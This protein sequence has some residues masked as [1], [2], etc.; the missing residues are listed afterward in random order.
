VIPQSETE[1]N[2]LEG[3]TAKVRDKV[4]AVAQQAID[5]GTAV[6]EHVAEQA[7][8]SARAHGLSRDTSLGE[9]VEQAGSGELADAAENVGRDALNAAEQS[10]SDKRGGTNE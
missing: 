3:V 1:E 5:R 2:A 6:A 10:L 8:A 9:I 7:E 4:E